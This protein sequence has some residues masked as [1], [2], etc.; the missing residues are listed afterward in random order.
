MWCF[1]INDNVIF[2]D[3]AA[4]RYIIETQEP[5]APDSY[6]AW[7]FFDGILGQ[8]EYFSSYVFE[9]MAADMLVKNPELKEALEAR[10]QE[11]ENFAKSARAQLDFIYKRS[12]HYGKTHKLYPVGRLV[13]DVEL[14]LN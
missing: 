2:S 4:N 7:N 5:H 1:F 14:S 3:Q 9:D 8:K 6:F 13:A 11:D 10:K 12:P